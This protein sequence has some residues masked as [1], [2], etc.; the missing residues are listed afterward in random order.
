MT[1]SRELYGCWYS[2]QRLGAPRV[3]TLLLTAGVLVAA[4]ACGS[5]PEPA[6]PRNDAEVRARAE[7][8]WQDPPPA[9]SAQPAKPAGTATDPRTSMKDA[10]VRLRAAKAWGGGSL[11]PSASS[12][13]STSSHEPASCDPARNRWVVTVPHSDEETVFG[14]GRGPT[15]DE[16]MERGRAEAAKSIEV[17][18]TS[19]LE[20][21]QVDWQR[22]GNDGGHA[23]YEAK[24]KSISKSRAS[25]RLA[26]CRQT[27]TCQETVNRVAV[28]VTCDRR[29]IL[30]KELAGAAKK[31]VTDVPAKATLLLIPGTESNGWV[32]GFGEYT[33]QTVRGELSRVVPKDVGLLKLP[34]WTPTDLRELARKSGATEF[35]RLEHA[36]AGHGR[37]RVSVWLQDPMTDKPTSAIASFDVELDQEQQ[38]LLSVRG[39]LL[40]QKGVMDL[41]SDLG[42]RRVTLRLNK[43]T[44]FEGDKVEIQIDVTEPSYVYAF[45]LYEQ[46]EVAT[47][48][49]GPDTPDN[50]ATPGRHFRI[51]DDNWKRNGTSLVACP[52][53]GHQRTREVI[54]A[55]ASAS[56]LDLPGTKLSDGGQATAEA[57]FG[58]LRELAHSGARFADASAAYEIV[59]RPSPKSACR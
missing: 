14:V 7:K 23:Q 29:G 3:P 33:M 45:D 25:R 47:L 46:G 58:K 4:I 11:N 19:T 39:P 16:A 56:P 43:P 34:T 50:Y 9:Q 41:A 21:T 38:E 57:I 30:E 36:D 28:L 12:K 1:V 54:K 8:A 35:V 15:L 32:T 24:V 26:E 6:A 55:I 53:R 52:I 40:P 48:V 51:P 49:P 13:A 44:F 2:Q 10:P 42:D 27:D 5:P 31:L 22:S 17:L 37:Q 18:V 59:A 20:D